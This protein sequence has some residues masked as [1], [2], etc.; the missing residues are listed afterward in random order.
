MTPSSADLKDL[1]EP[2]K[3]SSIVSAISP[4][5]PSD[6]DNTAL[7]LPNSSLP[8]PTRTDQALMASAP[9]IV[10]SAADLCCPLIPLS[11]FSSCLTTSGNDF[12]FPSA[13]KTLIPS[14]S[15]SDA[16][17]SVGA[18]NDCKPLLNCLPA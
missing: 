12:I 5:A 14:S 3:L 6:P 10:S 2:A 9:K 11:P 18:A 13:S 1:N 17:P 15:I 4:A 7:N 16:A 8:L